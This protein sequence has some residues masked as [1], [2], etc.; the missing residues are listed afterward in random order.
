M[1]KTPT[2]LSAAKFLSFDP[3]T[4]AQDMPNTANN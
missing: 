4:R 3:K 2:S 1:V